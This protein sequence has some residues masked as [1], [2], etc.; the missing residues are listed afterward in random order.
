MHITRLE[1]DRLLAEGKTD[2]A[3]S[4]MEERRGFF[5]ENGYHIRRLNQAYFAFHGSYAADPGGAA[6]E[7]GVDLGQEL[8]DLRSRT[9]SYQE[10]MRLVAWRWKLEQF[11]ELFE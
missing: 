1:V 10:F 5:W 7:E 8:R 6:S 3:E 4:F 11:E 2:E 9:P